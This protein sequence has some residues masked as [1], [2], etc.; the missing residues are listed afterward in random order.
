MLLHPDSSKAATAAADAAAPLPD[1]LPGVVRP[2][3][4]AP[5]LKKS[6]TIL[7]ISYRAFLIP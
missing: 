1:G 7:G 5:P 3:L 6:Q 4:M 2:A